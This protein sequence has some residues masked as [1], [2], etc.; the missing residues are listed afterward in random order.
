[1][2]KISSRISGTISFASERRVSVV[3][4]FSAVSPPTS[5]SPSPAAASDRLAQVRDRVVGLVGERVVGERHVDPRELS[6]L[7][8]P[9]GDHRLDALDP[10][11]RV[12]HRLGGVGGGRGSSS[13]AVWPADE[14]LLDHELAVDRLGRVAE[15]LAEVDDAAVLEVAR[16]RRARGSRPRSRA[17]ASSARGRSG[18]PGARSRARRCCSVPWRGIAGQK[19]L[20]PSAASSAGRKVRPGEQHDG[21]ARAPA[22]V[23]SSGS[24]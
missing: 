4:K 15:A 13:T 24:P 10:P 20:R 17:R 23:P 7:G 2:R 22:P 5:A 6:V 11:R 1:M 21:D 9:G 8:G 16:A 19:A 3:S 14:L 12:G 18:R